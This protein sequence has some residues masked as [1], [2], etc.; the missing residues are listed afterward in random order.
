MKQ[1]LVIRHGKSDWKSPVTNDFGRPLNHRGNKN[2]P[3]MAKR[4]LEKG[5]A[6]QHLVS[7]PAVRALSTAKHFA[8]AW[9]FLPDDIQLEPSIYEASTPV[10]LNLL[11]HFKN[12]FNRIA[13][14]GHNPGFTD[15]VNYL[16]DAGISN[17]PTTGVVVINFDVEDWAEI[18]HHTGTMLL[19]DFPKNSDEPH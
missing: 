13:M 2:G 6:P 18:S 4:V 14:F 15:F 7:S 12:K 1:L 8:K 10:L 3:A 5:L 17:I 16:S 19:F 9:N 11:N